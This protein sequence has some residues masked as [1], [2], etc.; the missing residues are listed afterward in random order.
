MNL[1]VD[2]Y[3]NCIE[4]IINLPT[5]IEGFYHSVEIGYLSHILEEVIKQSKVE[6]N[7]EVE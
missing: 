5:I 6:F 4:E 1:I 7:Y 2:K 3:M